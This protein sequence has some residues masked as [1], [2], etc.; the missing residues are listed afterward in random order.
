MTATQPLPTGT[1]TFLFTDIEGSTRAWDASGPP[2]GFAGT[3]RSGMAEA[4][5]RHDAMV[6]EVATTN[7]GEV[8]STAGDAFA[9]AF[10]TAPD[11]LAASVGIQLALRDTDW[12]ALGLPTPLAVRMALHTGIAHARDGDYFGPTLNRTARILA[13]GHGGQVLLSEGT[14]VLIRDYLHGGMALRDLGEHRLRDLA[15][16][17]RIFQL[18]CPPLTVDFPSLRSLDSRPHNLPV[19]LTAFVGR[20]TALADAAARLR[21]PGTR[22]LT[23]LGPGGTGKT[24]IALQLAADCLDDFRDGAFFVALAPVRDTEHV[25]MAIASA[26]GLKETG[27]GHVQGA[28]AEYLAT[29]NLLLVLDNFEQVVEA[30][31]L[32]GDLLR[33]A[34]GLKVVITSREALRIGGEK[35][36]AIPPLELPTLRPVPSLDRLVQFEAVRLF[37]DR[38]MAVKADFAVTNANAPAVAEIC[39][40]LDGLP[41]AIELAASRVRL[42]AP[43]ALLARLSHAM[44][45]TLAGGAR[46]LSARQQTLRGAIAWSVDLLSADERALFTRLS[47][48]MGGFTVEAA[49]AVGSDPGDRGMVG[50]LDVLSGMESLADKSLVRRDGGTATEPRFRML[51]TIRDHASAMAREAGIEGTLRDRH[52]AWITELFTSTQEAS[53]RAGG[54]DILDRLHAELGNLRQALTWASEVPV[55]GPRVTLGLQ[56]CIACWDYWRLRHDQVEGTG[57]L[58]RLLALVDP[59]V[60]G[61]TGTPATL[62]LVPPTI[63]AY[64][65]TDA[66]RIRAA[67]SF[68]APAPWIR[69][70][71][72]E[73]VAYFRGVGDRRGEG[74]AIHALSDFVAYTAGDG[75]ESR[76]LALAAIVLAAD[77]G[78]NLTGPVAHGRVGAADL[79][80][81]H[82]DAA[83][84]RFA[85]ALRLAEASG[86]P[87]AVAHSHL[88]LGVFWFNR[89]QWAA[90]ESHLRLAE[91]SGAFAFTR[92][93]RAQIAVHLG[94]FPGALAQLNGLADLIASGH[95]PGRFLALVQLGCGSVAR[96][97]GRTKEAHALFREV[98]ASEMAMTN[99]WIAQVAQV[100]LAMMDGR[101][102][103]ANARELLAEA[104]T[105]EP[106]PMNV[107]S[108]LPAIMASVAELVVVTRPATA[109]RLWAMAACLGN[110][111][112]YHPM[113]VQDVARITAILDQ[114]REAHGIPVPDVPADLTAADAIAECLTALAA[115]D[116]TQAVTQ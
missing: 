45:A 2:S 11:G 3:S 84:E 22:L 98:L 50:D 65:R 92:Y 35:V 101:R 95:R 115:L 68:G 19:Q 59:L 87:H 47:V 78:D 69:L 90:S 54:A 34:P 116:A 102:P 13:T 44:G 71:L 8:F 7:G 74:R 88:L 41:L 61:G 67:G 1:V 89:C 105:L 104:L 64:A 63:L 17:E 51:E 20:E 106:H 5:S 66:M 111:A 39:H 14:A 107:V 38:A 62:D 79:V 108:M 76:A 57:A 93:L 12:R 75:P 112:R 52:L 33:A 9:I 53:R 58:D 46:D 40:R 70:A 30:S 80:A 28:L 43:G 86:D 94:D 31:P 16:P 10:P 48:F 26:L 27:G 15:R 55:D 91:G 85:T 109:L 56:L 77:A 82:D 24:R 4:L 100:G 73:A 97:E 96:L 49:E 113:Y 36:V 60:T 25:G 21:D 37:I 110:R 99:P 83:G 103:G 72:D 18:D 81:G 42:F 114:A 29:R 32:V 23:L 6:R